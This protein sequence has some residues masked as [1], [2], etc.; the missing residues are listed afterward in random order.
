MWMFMR[1]KRD[2]HGV[3]CTDSV[4]WVGGIRMGWAHQIS[5]AHYS[6]MPEAGKI[7]VDELLKW[8]WYEMYIRNGHGQV[9]GSEKH[10]QS[11]SVLNLYSF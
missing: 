5:L 6:S 11:T 9:S 10:S 2:A 4:G 3:W 8:N 7:R 1:L